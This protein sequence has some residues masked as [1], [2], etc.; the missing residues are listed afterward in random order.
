MAR[1]RT[2]GPPYRFIA[3]D[4]EI[5]ETPLLSP[6]A[7]TRVRAAEHE[8]RVTCPTCNGPMRLVIDDETTALHLPPNP[9]AEHEPED[10]SL[11]RAKRLLAKHLSSLFPSAPLDIDVHMPEIGHLADVV[12]ITPYGGRL[13]VE[14]QLA[15]M[16]AADVDDL[17]GRYQ[18]HGIRCLWALDARRLKLPKR[19]KQGVV[20]KATLEHLETALISRG[21][22]LLF[23]DIETREVVWLHPNPRARELACLGESRIGRVECLIRRY[24]LSQLRVRN[25]A[26]WA[27]TIFDQ[28]PPAPPALPANLQ[29][30]LDKRLAAGQREPTSSEL[31]R[32]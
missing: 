5:V 2:E 8:G 7:I 14:V 25:G 28:R 31:N 19:K 4:N 17:V 18:E 27:P 30:K 13:A 15:D 6:S 26:W 29:R 12:V 21:E 24:P 16:R 11:R 20:A 22:P 32:P 10:F 3:L 1:R 23:I 9:F